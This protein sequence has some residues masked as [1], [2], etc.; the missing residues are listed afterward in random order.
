MIRKLLKRLFAPT[1]REITQNDG[2]SNRECAVE[3]TNQHTDTLCQPWG[4]YEGTPI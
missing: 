3:T 4:D 1:V 2:P